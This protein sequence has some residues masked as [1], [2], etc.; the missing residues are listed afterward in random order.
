MQVPGGVSISKVSYANDIWFLTDTGDVYVYNDPFALPDLVTI[1]GGGATVVDIKSSAV[2]TLFLLSDGSVHGIGDNDNGQLGGIIPFSGTN[3]VQDTG[4]RN[5]ILIDA[6][7]SHSIFV[8]DT[9]DVKVLGSN[10]Y[11]ELASEN[12]NNKSDFVQN[13]YISNVKDIYAAGDTSFAVTTDNK[14]WSWGARTSQFRGG[15]A[16][17]PGVVKDFSPIS[18]ISSIKGYALSGDYHGNL[19]LDNGDIYTFGANWRK[20][21]GRTGSTYDPLPLIDYYDTVDSSD[22]FMIDGAQGS[23]HGVSLNNNGKLFTWGYDYNYALGRDYI[24]REMIDGKFQV[25][26]HLFNLLSTNR[27][28]STPFLSVMCVDMPL[29]LLV[30]CMRGVLTNTML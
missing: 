9:F 18:N 29:N 30:I 22:M 25:Y 7:A 26:I 15:D 13:S 24:F 28:F 5:A 19:V 4:I 14:M 16:T 3:S 2:H 6:G 20:G 27:C 12:D 23:Y 17:L 11:G 8:T 1:N 10:Y 21:N